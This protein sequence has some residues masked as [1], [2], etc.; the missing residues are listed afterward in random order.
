MH[1]QQP[2]ASKLSVNHGFLFGASE[3]EGTE[4]V[5]RRSPHFAL[6]SCHWKY[7]DFQLDL[8]PHRFDAQWGS[9]LRGEDGEGSNEC[10]PV[11]S[12]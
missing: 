6:G 5:G 1:H 3:P 11:R 8:I 2:G 7:I 12:R 9:R 4:S 10:R